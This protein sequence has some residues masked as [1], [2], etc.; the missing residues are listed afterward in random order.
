MK[1]KTLSRLSIP[2][3][4]LLVL[5]LAVPALTVHSAPASPT[6]AV[7]VVNTTVDDSGGGIGCS[8]REAIQSAN[9]GSNFGGCT[10]A[11]ASANTISLPAGTY[12]LTG[13][14]GEDSNASGDLDI[15]GTL[16]INGAGPKATIIRAGTNTTNGVDRVLHIHSGATVEIN[17]VAVIYGKAP[18]GT[19]GGAGAHGGGIY[20]DTSTLTLNNCSVGQNRAGNGGD[21]S[22]STGGWG[23]WGGG[24]YNDGGT[25]VLDTTLVRA[26]ETGAG[27]DGDAGSNGG[28]GGSGGGISSTGV[29]TLTSSTVESNA[30]GAGGNGGDAIG[31]D[32][33]NGGSS[34]Y[35]GGIYSLDILTL[36]DS[37]I[38][39]NTTGAGGA[40]GD[41]TGGNG[42][43]GD[44]GNSGYGAGIY[45]TGGAAALMVIGST[46]RDNETG[47]GGSGGTGGGTGAG[48]TVGNRGSAGGL[49]VNGIHATLTNSTLSGNVAR[50]GGGI[51]NTGVVTLTNC[52]LSSN[53]AYESGGGIDGSSGGKTI[54]THVTITKNT[55]D[56][57]SN[58]SGDG[59]GFYSTS[60]TM[61]N[62]L[63]ANNIDKGGQYP[64]CYGAVIVSGDYNLLGI[65]GNTHC[66]FPAQ[67]HDQ[68]GTTA[69]PLDPILGLLADNGG[70]TLTHAIKANGPA[71]NQIPA[72]VNGCVVG[73]RDQR[74]V[75]RLP[76][77]DIGA[78]EVDP[79]AVYLPLVVKD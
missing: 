42:D 30:T 16:T 59:G 65:G 47:A 9:A 52:T 62:T 32:A 58:G 23:G 20:N 53:R 54:L 37:T 17:G 31:G 15:S 51:Y 76:L 46:I 6:A 10:G 1:G 63:V 4:G 40:G 18:D 36:I 13:A 49:N 41:V 71:A 19:A 66:E 38:D 60:I 14:A 26:N 48:G 44:G 27:G 69:S 22:G 25:L 43:G 28:L 74:G 7:I 56:L 75:L 79:E 29:V 8:L 45:T 70:P 57:D 3:S 34:G 11:N 68:V 61:T 55:A 33:G 73:S 35:G 50:M 72:G 5:L 39:G 77:C 64:D 67:A 78:Y 12:T 24:I 21:G 2:V